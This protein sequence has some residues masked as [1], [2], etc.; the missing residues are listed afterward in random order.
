M[1]PQDFDS[2]NVAASLQVQHAVSE[3]PQ[4]DE[5]GQFEQHLAE[6]SQAAPI[7]SRGPAYPYLSM[8]DRNSIDSLIAKYAAQ[9]SPKPETVEINTQAL[10]RLVNDLRA[11]G[12]EA[13]LTDYKRLLDHA[14]TYLPKDKHIKRALSVLRTQLLTEDRK[15]IDSLISQYA[16]ENNLS[17]GTVQCYSR[18]LL[19]LVN[20]L[21]GRGQ[22]TDLTDHEFLLDH[23][24]TYFPNDG[25]VN[26]GVRVLLAHGLNRDY[27]PNLFR[28]DRDLIDNA[29]AQY[30]AQTNPAPKTVQ[31][32]TRALRR[33]GND[34]R[35]RGQTTDLADH[36]APARSRKYLLSRR[37]TCER[38]GEGPFCVS[39][40]RPQLSQSFSRRPEPY[41]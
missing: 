22:P 40:L 14:N 11:R 4:T 25:H 30:V 1:D 10:R 17:P 33:L 31:L 12:Q 19:R 20:D 21:R 2:F 8:E 34:L 15:L 36:K 18:A 23:V 37:R 3:A 29:I 6:A 35:S 7:A 41:R 39:W 32:Y 5:A 26:A 13:K 24:N 27:Y 16:A 9:K 28:E 38:R